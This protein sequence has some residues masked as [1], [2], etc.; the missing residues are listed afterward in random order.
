MEVLHPDKVRFAADG[1]L[2]HTVE[3]S[4][5]R[6]VR[7]FVTLWMTETAPEYAER[8]N[9]SNEHDPTIYHRESTQGGI[10][11]HIDLEHPPQLSDLEP[12]RN[13]IAPSV[14]NE[15]EG[16]LSDNP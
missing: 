7:P 8:H 15:I 4:D 12:F 14:M 10:H 2:I 1:A 13:E 16:Y 6:S 11:Y 3:L 5:D 9:L